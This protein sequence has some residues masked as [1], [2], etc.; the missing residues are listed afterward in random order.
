MRNC[1]YSV[2]VRDHCSH[3]AKLEVTR[4]IR[5]RFA[6]YRC[7]NCR[8]I[9]NSSRATFC[10][11]LKLEYVELYL[12]CI[13]PRPQFRYRKLED[14]RCIWLHVCSI[15][16]IELSIYLQYQRIYVQLNIEAR[17]CGTVFTL[18][19]SGPQLR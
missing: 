18:Y 8:H 12:H 9:S 6:V 4:W 16:H 10:L 3:C 15:T 2:Y 19:M 11:I 1:I 14:V 7:V 5:T 13:C 17:I